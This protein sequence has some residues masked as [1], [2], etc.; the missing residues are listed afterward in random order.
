MPTGIRM[1][2][3]RTTGMAIAKASWK[4]LRCR[5]VW[6]VGPSGP[7]MLQAKKHTVNAASATDR[8]TGFDRC[9]LSCMLGSSSGGRLEPAAVK[10]VRPADVL[11]RDAP[12]VHQPAERERGPEQPGDDRVQL[13][14]DRG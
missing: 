12:G 5:C 7:S 10:D 13:V 11:E 6:S 14:D 9:S 4:S 8:A 2:D 1:I 3:P